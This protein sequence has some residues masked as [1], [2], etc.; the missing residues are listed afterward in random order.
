MTTW[1]INIITNILKS[2]SK[3]CKPSLKIEEN[4]YEKYLQNPK[5]KYENLE[6]D[7]GNLEKNYPLF[8]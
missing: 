1:N 2:I 7:N 3:A 6:M 8:Q 5:P 4:F